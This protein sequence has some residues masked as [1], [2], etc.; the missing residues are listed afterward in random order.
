MFFL[1]GQKLEDGDVVPLLS[2]IHWLEKTPFGQVLELRFKRQACE[3]KKYLESEGDSTG[4][5]G[6]LI[7]NVDPVISSDVV[8]Q[9]LQDNGDQLPLWLEDLKDE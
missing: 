3:L 1:L 4:L 9:C 6:L 2:C 5:V 7:A 8:E